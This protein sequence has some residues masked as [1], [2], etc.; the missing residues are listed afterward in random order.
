MSITG[1]MDA[2]HQQEAAQLSILFL[3]MDMIVL[4]I[5]TREMEQQGAREQA[6]KLSAA[7]IVLGC[8][9]NKVKLLHG[10]S[11]LHLRQTA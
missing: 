4:R 8:Q 10:M 6:A 5:V 2:G 11:R 1:L 7:L 3:D 9:H